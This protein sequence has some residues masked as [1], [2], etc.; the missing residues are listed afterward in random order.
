M[1]LAVFCPNDSERLLN[2]AVEREEDLK[3]ESFGPST[4]PILAPYNVRSTLFRSNTAFGV[5]LTDGSLIWPY[6]PGLV[7][8]RGSFV[9]HTRLAFIAQ[10]HN[11][12]HRLL[13]LIGVSAPQKYVTRIGTRNSYPQKPSNHLLPSYSHPS[14]STSNSPS[15]SSSFGPLR[16]IQNPLFHRGPH[17][18]RTPASYHIVAYPQL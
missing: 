15:G 2:A 8:T 9:V 7:L 13:R 6:I 3:G 10:I 1:L 17:P 11:A 18:H 14:P 12:S 4:S 5:R 16:R